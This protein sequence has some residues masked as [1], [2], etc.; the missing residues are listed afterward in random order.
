MAKDIA[1]AAKAAAEQTVSGL[2]F[3]LADAEYI[4]ENGQMCL[5]FYIWRENGVNI[6]DCETV[7]RAID[8]VIEQGDPTAGAPYCLCVSTWGD[9]P[10]RTDR[11]MERYMGKEVE[12]KLKTPLSGKKKNYAGLLQAFDGEKITILF[13]NKPL[14]IPRAGISLIRPYIGF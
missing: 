8:P 1:A 9:R 6:E 7:S 2:G 14:E 13:Q 3:E 11:D 10:L 5:N 12:I 4:R